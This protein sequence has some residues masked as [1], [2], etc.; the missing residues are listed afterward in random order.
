MQCHP[1]GFEPAEVRA[2]VNLDP[3]DGFSSGCG[4]FRNTK[5]A[6]EHLIED[7]IGQRIA[8]VGY[9]DDGRDRNMFL[10]APE[11]RGRATSSSAAM[12]VKDMSAPSFAVGPLAPFIREEAGAQFN[13][14][15]LHRL[16]RTRREH[17]STFYRLAAIEKQAC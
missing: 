8:L 1:K 13:F 15:P 2:K 7:G 12:S 6:R 10:G 16:D 5:E 4:R 9:V 17:L 11:Q 14:R 3:L